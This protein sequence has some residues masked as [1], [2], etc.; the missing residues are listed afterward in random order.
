MR[1][2]EL[3]GDGNKRAFMLVQG[4]HDP[5]EIHQTP[6]ESIHFVDNNAVHLAQLNLRHETLQCRAF[7]VATGKSAIIIFFRQCH[8]AFMA[9]RKNECLGSLPLGIERIEFLFQSLIS[10]FACINGT[11]HFF[12]FRLL[13]FLFHAASFPRPKKSI[14]FQCA[15]VTFCATDVRLRNRSP[16]YSNPSSRTVTRIVRRR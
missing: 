12:A 5:A 13:F 14:P 1:G 4:F 9:L 6:G 15:P 10:R 7:H 16:S 11:A 3:L 8:P 2:V